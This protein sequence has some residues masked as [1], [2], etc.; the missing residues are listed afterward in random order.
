MTNETEISAAR[1]EILGYINASDSGDYAADCARGREMAEKLIAHMAETRFTP[2][3]G[4]I[5][6]GIVDAGRWKT[7]HVGFFQRLADR[8]LPRSS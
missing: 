1:Q 8:S 5:C 7:V 4:A 6:K 2:M 3:L